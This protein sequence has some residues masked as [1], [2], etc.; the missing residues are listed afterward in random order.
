MEHTIALFA[1]FV[2]NLENSLWLTATHMSNTYTLAE[3]VA[4]F[5][6]R[7]PIV[8]DKRTVQRFLNQHEIHGCGSSLSAYRAMGRGPSYRGERSVP[9]ERPTRCSTP[10]RV[11]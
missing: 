7:S 1:R 5:N 10:S 9:D 4:A 8:R 6:R 2:I 3:C 11:T